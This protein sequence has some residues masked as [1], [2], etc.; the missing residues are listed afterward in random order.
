[1]LIVKSNNG[2]KVV[3]DSKNPKEKLLFSGNSPELISITAMDTG[4]MSDYD[5]LVKEFGEEHIILTDFGNSYYYTIVESKIPFSESEATEILT[6]FLEQVQVK[7]IT[8]VDYYE[9]AVETLAKKGLL[10]K[11]DKLEQAK[12]EALKIL[13]IKQ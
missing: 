10:P 5:F 6:S 3:F 11:Y 13:K 1:M 7:M 12:K 9:K 4:N 8:D 2:Q